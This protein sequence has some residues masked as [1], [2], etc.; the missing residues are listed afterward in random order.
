LFAG[1]IDI[2][3]SESTYDLGSLNKA[4]LHLNTFNSTTLGG[5]ANSVIIGG[6]DQTALESNTV[7]VPQ[8]VIKDGDKIKSGAGYGLLEFTS[9]NDVILAT[10]KPSLSN[11]IIGI[12]SSTSS[13]THLTGK[14]GILVRDTT[15]FSTTPNTQS[16]V[17]SISSESGFIESGIYNTVIIG[18]VNLSA[19]E[20]NTVYLGNKVNIN[21]VYTLP[22]VDGSASEVLLTDGSGQAYWGPVPPSSTPN[23]Y[24]VLSQGNDSW[25][26][27]IMM[28]TGTSIVSGNGG[29]AIYLDESSTTG[30]VVI[31]TNLGSISD[32]YIDM[33][34]ADVNIYSP[35]VFNLNFNSS[36]IVSGNLEGLK[37]AFDYSASFTTYSLVDKN[38]VDTNSLS[39]VD[40]TS[41]ELN[42]N[43]E[44]SLKSIID[45]NRQFNDSVTILGDLIVQGTTSTIYT[46][47]LYIEDNFIT[48]NATYSGPAINAGIEANLGDGTYSK[49]LW[50]SG[51][52]YWEVGLSGSES[53]I[54]TEA[55]NGLT[56]NGNVVSLGGTLSQNTT[57]NGQAY[58][59]LLNGFNSITITA[60]S[61]IDDS[62]TDG[63]VLSQNYIEETRNT[64]WISTLD[65]ATY[66]RVRTTL[67]GG[68]TS[69]NLTSAGNYGSS[70][71]QL[72]STSSTI[73]DGS[74]NNNIVVTDLI[75]QKG[76][77]YQDDYSPNFT[78][79]SLVTK[80][81]VDS[82]GSVAPG[83]GLQ[84]ITPGVIGL[85]G[86]LSSTV[87]I[88]GQAK[89]LFLG[90][91]GRITMTSSTWNDIIVMNSTEFS[92]NY[93]IPGQNE[94]ISSTNDGGTFSRFRTSASNLVNE[95]SIT[96]LASNGSMGLLFTSSDQPIGDGSTNNNIIL[97]DTINQKGIV[98][99]GDYTA[100]F[101]TY[102]L[103]TKGYVDS[104]NS[105]SGTGTTNYIPRWSGSNTLSTTSS[106]YDNGSKVGI[107]TN[108]PQATL[109]VR[110]S[111]I[112]NED[113]GDFDFR[114]E[115]VGNQN[116]FFVDASNNNVGIGTNPPSSDP[117]LY[118]GDFRFNKTTKNGIWINSES[119]GSV[120]QSIG[121]Y[122][123][124]GGAN[125]G[126]YGQYIGVYGTYGSIN[127]GSLIY[128]S[129]NVP[130]SYGLRSIV[131][132]GTQNVAVSVQA[133]GGDS[134]S[135][136]L[137]ALVSGIAT[138]KY[139]VNVLVQGTSSTNYGLFIDSNEASTNYGIVVNRGTSVFN[140]S[141]EDNNFQ[142]KGE[143]DN[144]L[145]FV[146]A[147]S[148]TIAIGSTSSEYKLK[149][150]G[151][152]SSTT[153]FNTNG[154]NG[155]S[156]T[157]SA[158]G[159]VVT[160]TGGIITSVV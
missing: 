79:Y 56:K 147:S 62:V 134:S 105:I 58:D 113:G 153:G 26:S 23:L 64:L 127:T 52:G 135:I 91:L 32:S 8:L 7:Y 13:S 4:S 39:A 128:N 73:N 18:G 131:A 82:L 3:K 60:S 159:Q 151:T 158:D 65:N 25:S 66:S 53:V 141:G 45:G 123:Q 50:S 42:G 110:G 84:Y 101:T 137:D 136:G 120:T 28:G 90:S 43:G 34:Q 16:P 15:T 103:V 98:Y 106:V 78:T 35:G 112:F 40:N 104:M 74:T 118:V 132:D 152:V 14:N 115:G 70:N 38:Y 86:T 139:G 89:H 88:D 22:D 114:V 125:N 154:F 31:S 69:L 54:L 46:E 145:F 57:I 87:I 155:W 160:V 95:A 36:T 94:S 119:F 80:G 6:F 85:G 81:Y 117:M 24:Q 17:T 9:A 116:L 129:S 107:L 47:N 99:S 61:Y 108:S 144:N 97:T 124:V 27:N 67:S 48:L 126:N 55:E 19:T 76:I 11:S 33:T 143:N 68:I 111:V 10:D 150:V 109:D 63:F 41:I 72:S 130:L 156:G 138:T 12:F 149:V 29:G 44:V 21:N 5:V 140:E 1:Q 2:I 83:N 92:R 142:I 77:V 102:S 93:I 30:N 20:S 51:S 133:F 148:D 157:F 49:I 100:N 96:T 121:E 122:I 71:I 146:D 37:Y 75:N 59:I